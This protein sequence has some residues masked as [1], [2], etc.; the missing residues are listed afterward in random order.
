MKGV[1]FKQVLICPVLSIILFNSSI[2]A[3]YPQQTNNLPMVTGW[4]DDSH[5]LIQTLD[6]DKNTVLQ[7]VDIKTGT[8]RIV[9]PARSKRDLFN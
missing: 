1:I 7:N 4:T 5:Y 3:Q 2:Q 6:K 8:G 9:P